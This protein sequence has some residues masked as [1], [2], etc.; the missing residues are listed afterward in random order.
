MDQERITFIL[1]NLAEQEGISVEEI[2]SEIQ[3][4]IDYANPSWHKNLQN[5]KNKT[6]NSSSSL[7]VEDVISYLTEAVIEK[8][9]KNEK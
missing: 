7:S 2:K 1:R 5:I 3:K 4:A 9:K 8:R 6:D